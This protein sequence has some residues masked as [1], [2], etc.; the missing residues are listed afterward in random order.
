MLKETKPKEAQSSRSTLRPGTR[1]FISNTRPL[2]GDTSNKPIPEKRCLFHDTRGHDLTNG[3]AFER[4]TLGAK[5]EWI[6]RAGLCFKCLL[7]EHQSE[8]CNTVVSCEKCG[9]NLHNTLL[10]M[11]RRRPTTEDNGEE[12]RTT[13][14]A[15]C[16]TRRGGLSCSKIMFS[17]MSFRRSSQT[18]STEYM[19]SSTTRVTPPWFHPT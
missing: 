19:P 6:M 7:P 16:H 15:I 1:V 3:K 4:K 10:H 5:T 13:C 18:L 9:S 12:L 17:S 8:D 11:E 2:V 14:T